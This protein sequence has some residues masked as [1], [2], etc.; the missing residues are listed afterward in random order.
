MGVTGGTPIGFDVGAKKEG[1]TLPGLDLGVRGMRQGGQ[2]KLLVPPNLVRL[3][4]HAPAHG[5]AGLWPVWARQRCRTCWD[6]H[7]QA[8]GFSR[9]LTYRAGVKFSCWCSD[10]SPGRQVAGL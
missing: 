8:S 4:E 9:S 1:G 3:P 7:R 2:R 6:G 5:S 10:E